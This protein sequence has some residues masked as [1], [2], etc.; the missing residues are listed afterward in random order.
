[1]FRYKISAGSWHSAAWTTPPPPQAT[2]KRQ[3]SHHSSCQLTKDRVDSQLPQLGL[4]DEIPERYHL[5]RSLRQPVHALRERLRLLH[6]VSH[7]VSNSWRLYPSFQ[8][9]TWPSCVSAPFRFV[10]PLLNHLLSTVFVHFLLSSTLSYASHSSVL[11]FSTLQSFKAVK[12]P[13]VPLPEGGTAPACPSHPED[14]GARQELRTPGEK[15]IPKLCTD[16]YILH[17]FFVPQRIFL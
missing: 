12:V 1:M 17:Y 4:P 11:S 8:L 10:I 13:R 14:H 15:K 9:G 7:L 6:L 3:S 16:T 2:P 5:L